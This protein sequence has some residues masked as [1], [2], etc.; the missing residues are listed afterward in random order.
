MGYSRF[1]VERGT[2]DADASGVAIVN[3][4]EGQGTFNGN[5][6]VDNLVAGA[7][8]RFFVRAGSGAEQ[9]ICSGTADSA[10]TFTCSAQKLTL[11]GFCFFLLLHSERMIKTV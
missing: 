2:G 4:S 3:Y 8:Y 5:I 9:L 11:N 10:G 6:T 1:A 7:T